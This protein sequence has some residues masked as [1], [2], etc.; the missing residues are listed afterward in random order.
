[1][2]F[3]RALDAR[4]IAAACAAVLLC[5]AHPAPAQR[6]DPA[7]ALGT[8]VAAAEGA[9]Q[10]GE[11]QIAESHFR[12]ALLEGWM[13]V[14]AIAAAD[15]RLADARHAFTRAAAATA[16]S[17]AAE[18]ALAAV[19]TQ[20]GDAAAALPILSRLAALDPRNLRI[21]HLL[22]QAYV[23]GGH[24]EAAVQEL[25]EALGV[26]PADLETA[27]TLAAGYAR[28][29][30]F[31]AAERLFARV[32][33]A[34]P[35]PQTYVLIGRA[36]RDAGAYDRA[37]AALR[38]ALKMDPRVRRA[39]YYLG[40][41]A[42]MA[43]GVVRV[44]DAI[45]EFLQEQKIAPDDP[46]NN[47]R[48]GMALVVARREREALAPLELVARAP[49]PLPEAIEYLGR[50]QLG[51]GR[52]ADAV[53][54]LQRALQ[55]ARDRSAEPGRLGQIHYVLATALRESGRA[56]EAAAEFERA[57][58]ASAAR[59]T[60]D[61][62]RLERYLADAGEAPRTTS[63]TGVPLHAAILEGTTPAQRAAL[64][65]QASATLAR[66]SLNLGVLQ[67]Q[68]GRFTRAAASFEEAASLDPSIP[69]VQFSLGVAY[70]N[71]GDHAKAIP[72]LE[73]TVAAEPQDRE[74]A[75]MLAMAC[76]NAG[77]YA[78]AAALLADDP[79]RAADPSLEY[80]Y[81]TAL[82]RSDRGAEAEQVF[83][84]L[85]AAHGDAPALNVVLGQ[86]HAQ[87]GDFDAAVAALRRALQQKPDVAEANAT[88][89]VIYL[90][91]G[92][93]E[94][95][96]RALRA[97]LA[98]HAGDAASRY[99]L[100]TVLDLDG[101]QDAALAELRTLLRTRPDHANARYLL[102][103]ILLAR[104]DA[105]GARSHLEIAVR[106]APE[107]ANIHYQLGLAY[108][109]LGQPE[110]A[111]EQ[112]DQFQQLKDRQRK[113]GGAAAEIAAD[114]AEHATEYAEHAAEHAAEYA[115]YAEVAAEHA[116]DAEHAEFDSERM[117]RGN[118]AAARDRGAVLREAAAALEAGRR[119]DAARLFKEAADRF[120]SVAALLQ[121]ARLQ[122]GDGDAPGAI[123]SLQ[124]ARIL[125]P[126]SEEVLSAL[127]QLSL[128]A[129]LPVP[130]AGALEALTRMCPDVAQYHYLL[131][132]ALMTAGDTVRATDALQA[133]DRLEPGRALTLAALGLALNSRKQ[134]TDARAA[135]VRS[136]E[137]DPD[138]PPTI[139][140][141]AEAEASLGNLDAAERDARRALAA[142]PGEPTAHLVLG[143]VQF[144]HGRYAEARDAFVKAAEADPR[145]AKADYQLSLVYARL[146]DAAA[147]ERSL[148]SYRRKLAQI[149][150]TVK[151]MRAATLPV[152]R[153]KGIAR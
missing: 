117:Q 152:T 59:A 69:R 144:E 51:A 9:L 124:A 113:A 82:V 55:T 70:F 74:A 109:K 5:G 87:Q 46:L 150:E 77:Q 20:M 101:H 147:A 88:L 122:S 64:A 132:V 83:S 1:M 36:Y 149:D 127:A 86:A 26:A 121:L 145:S 146:G 62:E 15:G 4:R 137:L 112:F 85:L 143:M 91:Q 72:P 80:T 141:L 25:E 65:R 97:E 119:G 3:T 6:P 42:L 84:R 123:A 148:E 19:Q 47:L 37:A 29:K 95:A 92:K 93:L 44:E 2:V 133:A 18:E 98:A 7:A 48:L 142:S 16:D 54:T 66:T 153:P 21:R 57:S 116:A 110:R 60:T 32:A 8:A 120:H 139:A 138:S 34:R 99:T 61:R 100:A 24:H 81:G 53:V 13:I 128:G 22:A 126:N 75:R 136:L 30:K 115:E 135:L 73:R 50:A 35:I 131:G 52:A 56:A 31:D 134:F 58:Q 111:R 10:A 130:A 96:A 27:F 14:G 151:A 78:R 11:R 28:V 40:M 79:Q 12:S 114:Y 104:D 90:K 108:Q 105:E 23:A 102:G 118:A 33:T 71:A 103:K 107:D 140:A 17:R 43:E 41:V 125:A 45:G 38:R 39:H 63:A 129:R 49:Q 94:D 106:L 89:G 68:A 76:F 67:A